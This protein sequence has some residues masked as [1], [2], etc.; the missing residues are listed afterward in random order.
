MSAGWFF[1]LGVLMGSLAVLAGVLVTRHLMTKPVPKPAQ[2]RAIEH[3]DLDPEAARAIDPK[4]PPHYMKYF[5]RSGESS[6]HCTCHGD[7][8]AVGETVLLWPIPGHPEQG[9]DVFCVL[10]YGEVSQ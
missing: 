1:V 2:P 4:D 9:M 6:L 7:P 8:V 3:I 10:T 5:P